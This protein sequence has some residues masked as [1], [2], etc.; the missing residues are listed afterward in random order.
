MQLFVALSNRTHLLVCEDR[1]GTNISNIENGVFWVG[2]GVPRAEADQLARCAPAA[3][4][5]LGTVRRRQLR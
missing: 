1:L 5:L 3:A 4:I 2:R